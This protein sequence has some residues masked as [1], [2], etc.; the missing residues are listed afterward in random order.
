MS[1]KPTQLAL[2]IYIYAKY[3]SLVKSFLLLTKQIIFSF[4]IKLEK[5]DSTFLVNHSPWLGKWKSKCFGP[6]TLT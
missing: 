5:I 4:K 6:L 3:V 2:N 1:I